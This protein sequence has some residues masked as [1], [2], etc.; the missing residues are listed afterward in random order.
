[1]KLSAHIPAI[2]SPQRQKV[3]VIGLGTGVTA[4][5]LTLYPDIE[6]IDVAEISETVVAALPYFS[7]A[8]YNVH[9]NPKV[10]IHIGDA[11][12]ILGR[13]KEKWD[14]IIS[15]PSNPWVTGVDLL[16]TREFY[17]LAKQ[18]LSSN[19]ILL[20]WI[21]IYDSNVEMVGM[22]VNTVMQEFQRCHV[23][24]ANPGDLLLVATDKEF[25]RDDV[26]RAEKVLRTNEAVRASLDV[27]RLSSLDGILLRELWSPSYNKSF[28]SNFGIQTM[29]NPRL[30][31]MA[32]KMFFMGTRMEENV[33]L[34]PN[35]IPFMGDYLLVKKYPEWANFTLDFETFRSFLESSKD[36]VFGSDLL[37]ARA[38]R[39]KA[40]L[41]DPNKFSLTEQEKQ[42]F[43]VDLIS[44]ITGKTTDESAWVKVGLKEASYKRKAEAMMAHIGRHRNW[45]VPYPIDGLKSLLMEGIIQGADDFEKNWCALQ[46]AF[47]LI[48]ESADMGQIRAVLDRLKRDKDGRVLLKSG[49][50]GLWEFIQ[51]QMKNASP[52]GG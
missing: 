11:F 14:I 36:M 41:T 29:D 22:I 10:K 4:G 5:E 37:M 31:Y 47:I 3:M 38:I 25:T 51:T 43:M 52:V 49:D 33:L 44:I 16:F 6:R 42:F 7:D 8:T 45:I 13:S 18:R 32:G 48:Y 15:E 12:R 1:L 21:Q 35:S 26:E 2:L 17:T 46:T 50:E 28:F 27:I 23:F 34:G 20:Q 24:V 9:K 40:Y 30:H 39:L 19:G